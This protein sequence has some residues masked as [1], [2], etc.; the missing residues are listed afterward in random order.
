MLY[1]LTMKDRERRMNTCEKYYGERSKVPLYY[2]LS[3]RTSI[4]SSPTARQRRHCEGVASKPRHHRELSS[5]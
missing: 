1:F 5:Q 4:S 3:N 2:L